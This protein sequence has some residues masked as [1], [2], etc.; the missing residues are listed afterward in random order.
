MFTILIIIDNNYIL[1]TFWTTTF[2]PPL[3][4][5]IAPWRISSRLNIKMFMKLLICIARNPLSI[6]SSLRFRSLAY[7]IVFWQ[8]AV[9]KIQ[10]LK[11]TGR[12]S[13][14]FRLIE[15]DSPR[16]EDR[17]GRR[18]DDRKITRLAFSIATLR[19]FSSP[20]PGRDINFSG[21]RPPSST[22]PVTQAA[23]RGF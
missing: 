17:R 15:A 16:C 19:C 21:Y 13:S 2:L 7:V 18:S 23:P 4:F 20:K 11:V 14:G 8:G 5:A 10:K 22:V 3:S 1:T 12:K 6:E 9:S